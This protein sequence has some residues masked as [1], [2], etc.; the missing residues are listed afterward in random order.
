MNLPNSLT[1]SRIFLVPVFLTVL[2]SGDFELTLGG[3]VMNED[4]LALAIFL[5]AAATDFLDGYIAR[6]RGEVTTL[7]K[8]LDPIA[9]KLLISAA[10]ISLVELDRVP[11]W[12]V[13]VIV[14]REFAVS[15]LRYIALTEGVAISASSLGKGKMAAQVTAVALLLVEPYGELFRVLAYPVLTVAVVLTVLSMLDYFR[16]FWG[17]RDNAKARKDMDLIVLPESEKRDAS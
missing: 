10:F 3:F 6:S 15:G 5:S 4:W 9:D 17:V 14:G 8:L 16:G 2:L 11:A 13:V 7:G 1:L 12:V